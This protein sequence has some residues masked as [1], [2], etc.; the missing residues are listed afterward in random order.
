MADGN[1]TVN[2]SNESNNTWCTAQTIQVTLP[3]LVLAS[4]QVSPATVRRGARFDIVN[5]VSNTGAVHAQASTVEFR[6]S[7]NTVFGDADDIVL[8][9]GSRSV[10]TLAA[11]ASSSATTRPR[12]PLLMPIGNYYVCG[13]ADVSLQ[14]P[15]TNEAN[16]SRCTAVTIQITQ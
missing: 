3:D 15:E 5:Q 2:E 1:S 11:G 10:N 14:V 6:L 8:N 12:V 9:S 7:V 4:M 16:N 13:M